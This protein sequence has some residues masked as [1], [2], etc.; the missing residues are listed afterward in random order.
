MTL[1][2]AGLGE[3]ILALTSASS[4]MHMQGLCTAH[5]RPAVPSHLILCSFSELTEHNRTAWRECSLRTLS[6]GGRL[7]GSLCYCDVLGAC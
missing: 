4:D 1:A 7:L 6:T 2:R 3:G 5:S